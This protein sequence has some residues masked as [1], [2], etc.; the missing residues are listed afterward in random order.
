MPHPKRSFFRLM[1]GRWGVWAA[2]FSIFTI[3][4]FMFWRTAETPLDARVPGI[5]ALMAGSVA[6]LFWLLSVRRAQRLTKL[7]E[8]GLPTQA[9]VTG[10]TKTGNKNTGAPIYRADWR[11]VNGLEGH[12]P[13]LLRNRLP[14][15]GEKITIL[16]DPTGQLGGVWDAEV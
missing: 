13:P 4:F 6:L 8:I 9:S 15:V 12:T 1:M 14:P 5:I 11:T 10:H 16:V 2:F 3:P 7:R